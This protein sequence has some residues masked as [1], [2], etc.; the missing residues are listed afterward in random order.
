[1]IRQRD[2]RWETIFYNESP[3]TTNPSWQSLASAPGDGYAT[4][5]SQLALSPQETAAMAW[6]TVYV[7]GGHLTMVT[8]P[9]AHRHLLRAIA[10]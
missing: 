2:G 8:H 1:L 5:D 3:V 4:R 9:D 10:D 6:P 7:D